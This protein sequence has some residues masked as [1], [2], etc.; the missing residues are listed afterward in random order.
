MGL[1]SGFRAGSPDCRARGQRWAF[2][3]R[4]SN[5]R[6]RAFDRAYPHRL[7]MRAEEN[8]RRR[9]LR[10]GERR[11]AAALAEK[12]KNPLNPPASTHTNDEQAR[13]RVKCVWNRCVWWGRPPN[14]TR[15]LLGR[16]S[17]LPA[18]PDV[19]PAAT[20]P[21][22]RTCR[23]AHGP[24]SPRQCMTAAPA[25]LPACGNQEPY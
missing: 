7:Q 24:F 8:W 1:V 22:H 11:L 15:G 3:F 20:A 17:K 19:C 25:I 6:K 12:R 5:G 2:M 4:W 18:R 23:H 10:R 16:M 9:T 21:D 13:A 14:S